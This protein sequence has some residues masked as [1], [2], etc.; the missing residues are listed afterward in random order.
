MYDMIPDY[1]AIIES[2]L[3]ELDNST[4]LDVL[5][6]LDCN[7]IEEAIATVEASNLRR[8]RLSELHSF[9]LTLKRTSNPDR[10]GPL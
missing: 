6:D 5:M 8:I 10:G 3:I 9:L 7:R 2:Y 4:V 1:I